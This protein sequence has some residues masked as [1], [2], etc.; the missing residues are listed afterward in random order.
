LKE[1]EKCVYTPISHFAAMN[2]KKKKG[3]GREGSG[4]RGK[5]KFLLFSSPLLRKRMGCR[6]EEGTGYIFSSFSARIL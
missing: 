4:K 2:E 3:E 6:G 5:K 1:K